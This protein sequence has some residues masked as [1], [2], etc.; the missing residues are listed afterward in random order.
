MKPICLATFFFSSLPA[1][2]APP[3]G[4][5]TRH[6]WTNVSG[7][8]VPDLTN[9]SDYPD[10]PDTS[11]TASS[12]LAP[13]NWSNNYG[14]RMFGWVHAPVTG[15]YTFYLHADD[16]AELWLSTTVSPD[17]R[18]RIARVPGWTNAGDWNKFPEQTSPIIT[19]EAGNYYFIE[20][21]QKE[22]GGGDNL[23]VAWSYPGQSRTYVPGASLSPWQNLAP[24]TNDDVAHLPPGGQVRIP[25]LA[26][27]LDPNGRADIDP[28]S[29]AEGTP[30]TN[31]SLAID[32][33]NGQ[34]TY[35][36][37]GSPTVSDVFSYS[38]SDQAG[39]SSTANVVI[40]I[41]DA[42]RLPLATS[43][44]PENGPVQELTLVDAFPGLGF[45]AP[46]GIVSPPAPD[47]RLF[48]LEKGGDIRLIPDLQSP[49]NVRFM[50][51]DGL[52]SGR[53]GEVFQTSSEQGLLGL[54]FHPSYA[55]N[56][57]FFVVYSV[58]ISGVRYQR[59][60]EFA[61]SPTD[62][63]SANTGS[64]KILIEQRNEAGNHN[65]GD[66]H[67]GPDG[68]LYMSWG[69]E[70]NA[71]DTLNNSQ[72][73]TKDFWSS[74]TRIDVDLESEDYTPTD[75]TGSDD[76]SVPPNDHPAVVKDN[77]GNPRYEVPADNPWVATPV[78]NGQNLDVEDVRT[79]FWAAGLR[80]PWRMSFDP[81]TGDLWC[82]DVGQGAWEEIN[83]IER[84]ANYE[85]AFREGNH[86]G[87]KWNNRPS[88]WTPN[89]QPSEGPNRGPVWQYSHGSGQ[90]EGNSVTGG[91][92]YRGSRIPSLAGHYVF[93]DYGSGNIW[94]FDVNQSPPNVQRIA[95]EGGIV[96]FGHDP[97]NGDVLMADID[98]GLIRRLTADTTG[99][100]FPDT[101]AATG[102]FADATT[103]TPNPGLIPYDINLP[104]WSDHAIKSR[105]FGH[106]ET[107]PTLAYSRDGNW[108]F[109]TGSTWVKHFELETERGNPSTR[110][111]IETRVL[112]KTEEGSYGVSYRWNNDGTSATLADAAGEE[113]D[114]A[115]IDGGV[116]KNQRWRIPSHAECN[117]CHSPQAGHALSFQTRQ[118]N[119]PGTIGAFSGNFVS[120][121]ELTGYLS[122]LTDD[123][124]TLPR[125]V[126][127]SE[128]DY[129][130][131]ARARSW[132]DVNCAYC[133]SASGTVP[134]DWDASVSL[135]LFETNIVNGLPGTGI[136]D[137]DDRLVVP[138][139]E[140]H[141]VIVHRAAARNGY[142]RMPPLATFETDDTAIQL[143]IDWIESELPS[144]LS[145]DD[146]RSSFFGMDPQGAPEVDADLDGRDNHQE[147]LE[148][149]HPLLADAPASL[150]IAH[151]NGSIRVSLPE[152]SGRSLRLESSTD[153]LHWT[154]WPDPE[155]N[156]VPR[157]SGQALE[158]SIP[159]PNGRQFFRSTVEER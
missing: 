108:A 48:I 27:D 109:P 128:T 51:L 40:T 37:D 59:L 19:L 119:R 47:Q 52:V 38:I 36:H 99:D 159:D 114:L 26:N 66:L 54:A 102:L 81:V 56:G 129:S 49:S 86:N 113:F 132:L 21:L 46:V 33:V 155:N 25:V 18:R 76:D 156:G 12:F 146:W 94:S 95:G 153:L 121:L 104:F 79:E 31:G 134:T 87:V 14:T 70:G 126:Q 143:L 44:M 24:E 91:V 55:T 74:I 45:S 85:W 148:Q 131:E 106:P 60:S 83:L 23:G 43:T 42:P 75:G 22:E 90:F 138:G 2:C 15:D 77:L 110:K 3:T 158:I 13:T 58:N 82:G 105:W 61:V 98:N 28:G 120:V 88:G 68:Y 140:S 5:I 62:P 53:S 122:G 80:N 89:Q 69:D 124:T 6:V 115:I 116:S 9:L 101:L 4:S 147:Y 139:D 1:L 63:N 11:T 137:P 73:I 64:E 35:T 118:L 103:L 111:R 136:L 84:G 157:A 29:L 100:V 123:P 151:T 154:P 133:H 93:A 78:F 20:A 71:N 30:P 32:P 117:T 7:V 135:P 125:H 72:T 34:I 17:Q 65:G 50:D 41:S 130:L 16:N 67:F 150:T 112:V 107:S 141:S 142:T 8:A 92:V 144:R 97:T 10:S 57:R 149:T 152:L 127:P 39:A 145:Y 96:A